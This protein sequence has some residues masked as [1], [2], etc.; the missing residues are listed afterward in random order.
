M[1]SSSSALTACWM[2]LRKTI[3]DAGLSG[4]PLTFPPR[5]SR[6]IPFY[7]LLLRQHHAAM[8]AANVDEAMRL[9]KQAELLALR[10]NDGEPGILAGPDAP[11]CVLQRETAAAPGA[12]P[13]WGQTGDFII[14][15]DG[16]RVRIELDGMFGIGFGFWPGFSSACGGL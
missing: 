9:R 15:V 16:M 7:R 5:W 8:L 1:I 4:K 3:T 6:A 12:V 2:Q 11:G 14:T 13:L 10:L